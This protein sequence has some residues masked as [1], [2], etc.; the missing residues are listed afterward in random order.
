[1]TAKYIDD[2]TSQLNTKKKQ[3][4]ID[5]VVTIPVIGILIALCIFLLFDVERSEKVIKSALIWIEFELGWLYIITMIGT[6]I[7][8]IWLAFGR[9]AHVKLCAPG[10]QAQFSV[11][12]WFCM[13]FMTTMAASIM[14][15]GFVEPSY[16]YTSP[17]HG[18]EPFSDE[19]YVWSLTQTM[20]HWSPVAYSIYVPFSVTLAYFIHVRK[21][22]V[23]RVS[24][25]CSVAIGEKNANGWVGKVIDILILFGVIGGMSTSFGLAVPVVLEGVGRVTGIDPDSTGLL[26]G[27]MSAWLMVFGVSLY[28]GLDGGMKLI[29]SFT[30]VIGITFVGLI[31]IL[32]DSVFALKMGINSLGQML[33][34]LISMTTFMDPISK[35]G[36][37][38]SW[39]VFYWAWYTGFAAAVGLF[40][41][42]IS[43]GRTI[44]EVVFGSTVA[45]SAGVYIIQITFGSYTID[46][47]ISGVFDVAASITSIGT[48]ATVLGIVETLPFGGFMAAMH[49]ILLFAFVVTSLDATAFTCANLSSIRLKSD[50]EPAINSKLTW[51]VILML[52]TGTLTIIGGLSAVQVSSLI[53]SVPLVFIA[54]ILVVSLIKMLNEDFPVTDDKF[55]YVDYKTKSEER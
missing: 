15:W 6:S 1:M 46:Q 52:L 36:F 28:R 49:A 2:S 29:S 27:L 21:K 35:T 24:Q 47:Q 32:G 19:A 41:A 23:F 14:V 30:A 13:I 25:A 43:R 7:L 38:E 3:S 31:F 42:K 9:F 18:L 26:V 10:E 39:T 33:Q 44:R 12:S 17:P 40:I 20:F 50:D 45:I 4:Q 53:V 8:A 22:D 55:I 51:A 16:Y 11:A 5:Y 37:V 34:N 48:S 54:G